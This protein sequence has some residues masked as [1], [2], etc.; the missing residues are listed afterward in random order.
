M[1]TDTP[2][3]PISPDAEGL[4]AGFRMYKSILLV[5][6]HCLVPAQYQNLQL[7]YE[8]LLLLEK[9]RFM[10]FLSMLKWGKLKKIVIV[11]DTNEFILN[12]L[13]TAKMWRKSKSIAK[14]K[15]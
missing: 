1:L 8:A 7:W 11:T 6:D 9:S 10:P 5:L 4:V 15:V 12:Q 14:Y 2:C 3:C 13:T